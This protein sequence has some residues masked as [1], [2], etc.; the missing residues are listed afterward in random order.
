M[1]GNIH[2]PISVPLGQC[3]FVCMSRRYIAHYPA[4]S[5]VACI[6]YAHANYQQSGRGCQIHMR[7][8]DMSMKHAV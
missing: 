2:L 6:L 8:A 3:G 4:L 1:H 5:L 7:A